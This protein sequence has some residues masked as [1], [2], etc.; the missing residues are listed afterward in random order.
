MVQ[1][2]LKK[3]NHLYVQLMYLTFCRVS[4]HEWEGSFALSYVPDTQHAILPSCGHNVLLVGVSVHT[5]QRDTIPESK[6]KQM[7]K[8]KHNPLLQFSLHWNQY[9]ENHTSKKVK[10]SYKEKIW[11]GELLGCLKSQSFSCPMEFTVKTSVVRR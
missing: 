7:N 10:R 5:M 6:N 2:E 1:R 4:L 8:M 9:F 11:V 3:K